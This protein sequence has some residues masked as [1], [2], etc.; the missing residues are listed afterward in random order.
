MTNQEQTIGRWI[1]ILYRYGQLYVSKKLEPYNIG[2]AQYVILLA[3]YRKGGIKQEELVDYLKIDKGSIAKS[4]RKLEK[5]SYIQRSIDLDDKRA[6]KV[7]LTQ[8]ALDIMPLVLDAIKNWEEII[9]SGLS[10]GEKQSIEN[11]LHK[12]AKKAYDIKT[13]GEENIK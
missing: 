1:S 13:Y 5:E 10:E 2:R 7:F 12:M 3:L 6:N 8:K 11:S 9:I 4:I